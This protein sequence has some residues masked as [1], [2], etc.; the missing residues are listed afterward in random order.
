[1][2]YKILWKEKQELRELLP[3]FMFYLF[4]TEVAK[5]KFRHC[6][7]ACRLLREFRI[8]SDLSSRQNLNLLQVF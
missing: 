1:M 4:N 8:D 2:K 3:P 6:E 5:C 7:P